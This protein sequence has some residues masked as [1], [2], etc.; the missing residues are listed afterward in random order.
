MA[1][2]RDFY[3]VLG[4]ARSA[5]AEE[6][7]QAYFD[8]ARRLHPDKNLAPGETELFLGAQEAY[9]VLSNP[10]RR[11]KYDASLPPEE[12]PTLPLEPRAIYSRPNLLRLDEPQLVYVI[13][14]LSKPSGTSAVQAPPINLCLVLDRSTSMHGSNMDVL[15]TTAIQIM[16]K[17]KPQDTF[18]VV[19]FSDRAE[20]V[21]AASSGA[22]LAKQ[23]ARIQ[24]LQASGGTEIFSG[25]ELGYNE[26]SRNLGRNQVNHLILLTDGRTYGDEQK[27][28]DLA[29]KAAGAGIGIS[30][31][32]VGSEWN[33][34]FI[35][36]LVAQTGGSSVYLPRPQDIQQALLDKFTRLGDLYAEETRYEFTLLRGVELR[37]A[38]RLQPEA[39][40]LAFTSPILM[41]PVVQEST[42][43]VLME[44]V[45]GP[46]A[47]RQADAT[48]LEGRIF[49]NLTHQDSPPAPIELHLRLPVGEEAG[50]EPPPPE[51]LEALSR[52]KLY[53]LQEQARLE[54][55]AGNYGQAAE[56]LTRLATHLLAR[57]ERG[58]AKTALVE[59]ENLQHKKSFSQRG[60]KEIKYGTRALLLLGSRTEAEDQ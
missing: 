51:I 34:A 19:A 1:K 18:S 48:M 43:K 29:K 5:T 56:H 59:A 26:I 36:Q 41:G 40:P 38:F 55:S 27:C 32:G 11:A 17:L 45:V 9:E 4:L 8:A 23:E 2:P 46:E 44:F 24:M 42:L 50:L 25:L 57:G 7:R 10:K 14:E 22:D 39:G 12:R 52:L 53:R 15:K 47:V 60:G 6:I 3:T 28:L 13:V 21:V 16:R 31:L 58:L 35:D 54:L 49:V 30:G 33:D 20:V 37:Y